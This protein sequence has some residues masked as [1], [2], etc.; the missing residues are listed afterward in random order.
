MGGG[1]LK[2]GGVEKRVG[3]GKKGKGRERGGKMQREKDWAVLNKP[4]MRIFLNEVLRKRR[5]G[6]R[7]SSERNWGCRET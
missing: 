5:K 3:G 4:K 1:G 2:K 7:D 6:K